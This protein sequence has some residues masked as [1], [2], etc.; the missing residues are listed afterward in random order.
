MMRRVEKIEEYV[1]DECSRRFNSGISSGITASEAA[2]ALGINRNDA[3]TDL[4]KLFSA[5]KLIKKG[6]KPVEFFPSENK[7]DICDT[8][9]KVHESKINNALDYIIDNS[10]SLRSAFQLAK[11]AASYPPHGLNTLITGETGVGKNFL[12]E[13]MWQ[14]ISDKKTFQ[15][16]SDN[17]PFITFC[18]AE[19]AD[20]PQLL[21]SQLFGYAKG[22]FTGALSDKEGLVEKAD[23]GILF[24]DEVHRLPSA[25]QELLFTLIDKG[26]FRRI[27]DTVDRHVDVMI[28]CAT[29]EDISTS[30]LKTFIRR[31]PVH[32]YVPKLSERSPK[33]R[34]QLVNSFIVQE[35]KRINLP[36]W[37]SGNVLKLLVNYTGKGNIGEL[38]NIINLSCAKSYLSFL[39][40]NDNNITGTESSDQRLRH[41]QLNIY[42]LPQKVYQQINSAHYMEN[43]FDSKIFSEG[44][45]FYPDNFNKSLS[46]SDEDKYSINL[47]YFIEKKI[48][49]YRNLHLN[50]NEVELRVAQDLDSYHNNIIQ[51]MM[52][53]EDYGSKLIDSI[54][55]PIYS[56]VADEIL[57]IASK[58][59]ERIYSKSL[60]IAF[61]LHIQQFLERIKTGEI[62]Y[63]PNLENIRKVHE[64]EFKFLKEI[65]NPI[66]QKLGVS[67][68]DDELGFWAMFL[69]HHDSSLDSSMEIGLIVV[70]HGT[71]TA[72]SI[73]NFVNEVMSINYVYAVDAPLQKSFS[74]VFNDLCKL[75]L[76]VNKGK[77]VLLL[78]DMGSFVNMED[79]LINAT[80]IPCKI[81]PLVSPIL[82]LEAAK[83]VLS[84]EDS[85]Y[86]VYKRIYRS[87]YEYFVNQFKQSVNKAGSLP[88]TNSKKSADMKNVILTVC[89]TGYGSAS[90]LKQLL[91]EKLPQN[92]SIEI[93][94]LAIDQDINTYVQNLHGRVKLIVGGINPQI[95]GVPFI[96]AESV[97]TQEGLNK[98]KSFLNMNCFTTTT[99][100]SDTVMTNDEAFNLIKQRCSYFTPS[101]DSTVAMNACMA[102]CDGVKK[103]IVSKPYTSN[104]F[105]NI[106][107]HFLCML[108]RIH[109]NQADPM[110]EW[111][112]S[113][114]NLNHSL[115]IEIKKLLN[116]ICEPLGYHVPKSEICYY[117]RLL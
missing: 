94:A 18:C 72:S 82:V 66:S 17:I 73:A 98:I 112:N 43:R 39:S 27:G 115:Y 34:L 26:T 77:G 89:T 24:L 64:R 111:G 93:I 54:I 15:N 69:S 33:E 51:R 65:E 41:L 56:E 86:T 30:L 110:P 116:Q 6:K 3:S 79:D 103:K 36:I 45:M 70:G 55:S 108:E 19:Y 85:L 102:F 40:N 100:I 20:N 105:V 25:G 68:P 58:R 48:Q 4:N 38:R 32:I 52:V 87:Y 101:I 97:F 59:L 50:N 35:A 96:G 10:P 61:T 109:T 16:K 83:I 60:S 104:Y 90:V 44:F 114:I 21:L 91:A 62:I 28:I 57:E 23:H 12:A 88:S 107:L 67:I 113:I 8:G 46:L 1:K 47:Y 22:A 11:A 31:I 92:I 14:Y 78:V 71:S 117:L 95:P 106:S 75:V 80:G 9:P 2:E 29:T 5:G 13:A 7:A 76:K 49:A 42:D 37:V 74:D 81:I 99:E 84:T 63:N 53:S